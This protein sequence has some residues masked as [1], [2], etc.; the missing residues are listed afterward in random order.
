MDPILVLENYLT[1]DQCHYIIDHYTHLEKNYS[2]QKG[3]QTSYNVICDYIHLSSLLVDIETL[4]TTDAYVVKELD[5]YIYKIL[6]EVIQDCMIPY[7]TT[8]NHEHQTIPIFTHTLSDTGY[9]VRK[10]LG[11]T[12][13]HIDTVAPKIRN[14]QMYYRV[15]SVIINLTESDNELVFPNQNRRVSLTQGTII[16][17]PPGWTHPHYTTYKTPRYSIQTWLEQKGYEE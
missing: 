10:I 11:P 2:R 3:Y 5:R 9:E 17:F 12:R 15:L 16:V 14:H 6:Q 1:E 8:T 4:P 13:C 7:Y